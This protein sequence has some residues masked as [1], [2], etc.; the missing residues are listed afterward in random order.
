[1]NTAKAEGAGLWNPKL[2]GDAK[3]SVPLMWFNQ[4]APSIGSNTEPAFGEYLIL[5]NPTLVAMDLTDWSMRDNSLNFFWNT[6]NGRWMQ[7]L[8]KFGSLVLQPGKHRIIYL[9]NPSKYPLSVNEYEYFNWSGYTPGPQLTN[10][11]VNGEY[12]NGEGLYLEDSMGNIRTSMTNPC[13][14]EAMCQPPDWV[15]EITSNSIAGQIIP[16]PVALNKVKNSTKDIYNPVISFTPGGPIANVRSSLVSKGFIV[17]E[18]NSY[19][20]P[21]AAGTIVAVTDAGVYNGLNNVL[22]QRRGIADLLGRTRTKI[23]V[24]AATGFNTIPGLTGLSESN[25]K[26]AIVAAGF[27]VGTISQTT[28]AGVAGVIS[29]V[30]TG[31]AAVKSVVSFTV[32]T[33][34]IA[35]P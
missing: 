7:K 9:D 8:N 2:C 34:P 26:L 27:T 28:D 25:A 35:A 30:Q 11:S 24:H 22:Q 12:A 23:Y 31:K 5:Y 10:G 32:N 6:A 17:A 1:M 33:P 3:G 15:L 16:I 13:T 21:H 18:G 4:N 14:S 29:Q 20:S 19:D